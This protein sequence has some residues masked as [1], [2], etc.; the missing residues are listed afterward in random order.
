[1]IEECWLIWIARSGIQAGAAHLSIQRIQ[2]LCWSL[3]REVAAVE[4]LGF[5]RDQ[6]PIDAGAD[7]W[8]GADNFDGWQFC[9]GRWRQLRSLWRSVGGWLRGLRCGGAGEQQQDW[10]DESDASQA[11]DL[12]ELQSG[13]D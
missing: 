1:M 5:R 11:A 2:Q 9:D 6:I 8:R 13:S 12:L 10:R 4:H 7:Q 3:A